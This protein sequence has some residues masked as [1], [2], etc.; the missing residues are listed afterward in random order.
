M[1][2]QTYGLTK[3]EVLRY[4]SQG[5]RAIQLL[6]SGSEYDDLVSRFQSVAFR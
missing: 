3:D 4:I 1:S 5:K 6:A 2:L